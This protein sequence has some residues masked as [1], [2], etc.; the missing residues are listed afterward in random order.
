LPDSFTVVSY[1]GPDLSIR[2]EDLETGRFVARRY[3]K[4][5][6]KGKQGQARVAGE[7]TGEVLKFLTILNS[8]L[9]R[10]EIQKALGLKGSKF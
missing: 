1:K 2:L 10:M 7:V 9:T 6:T 3:R 4:G 8:P 5:K